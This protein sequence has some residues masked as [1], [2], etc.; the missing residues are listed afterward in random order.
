METSSTSTSS[1]SNTTITASPA[2]P[3]NSLTRS[4]RSHFSR[5]ESTPEL[6]EKEKEQPAERIVHEYER[7]L[8]YAKSPHSMT[9]P[10]DWSKISEQHP[11]LIKNKVNNSNN[12]N[13][14][15][16]SQY[17]RSGG[18]Q[19]NGFQKNNNI[20][21]HNNNTNPFMQRGSAVYKSFDMPDLSDRLNRY[22]RS[23][24]FTD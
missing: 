17:Y 10:R 22:S 1:S 23:L 16:N 9:L 2:V 6:K 19:N 24:S 15:V 3:M 21:N 20:N 8:F 14:N 7:L 13:N 11:F 5:K 4:R 18:M 12:I